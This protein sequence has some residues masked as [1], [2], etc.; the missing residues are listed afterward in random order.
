MPGKSPNENRIKLKLWLKYYTPVTKG[1]NL[2]KSTFRD[3]KTGGLQF[4]GKKIGTYRRIRKLRKS[5]ISPSE[6]MKKHTPDE[7]ELEAQRAA[8][9]DRNIV[10]SITVPLYN[11]RESFL[12]E[13]IDSVRAQTY[14]G[15]ELCL[16]DGSDEKHD[17][18]GRICREYGDSD[19]RIRYRKLEKNLGVSGN[20]NA[21][22]EMATGEF[23][24]FLDHDDVLAPS[25]LFRMAEVLSRQEADVLYTDEATFLSPDIHHLLSIHLKPDFAIDNLRANNY[26]C[27]FTAI[28][29]SLLDRVGLY[30]SEC[31][32]SQDHDMMLRLAAVTDRFVHIPEPLYFWRA[33]LNSTALNIET[34][35]Y[36]AEAG[37][38]AVSDSLRAAGLQASVESSS[39]SPTIYRIRYELTGR[40]KISIIIQ[41]CDRVF[42]LKR[43]LESIES[44]TTYENYE[45]ILI[46]N[47]SKDPGTFDYYEEIKERWSNIR[48]LYYKEKW[49]WSAANN[50]GVRAA[51]GDYY[52]LLNNDTEVITPDW[53]EEMLMY[54]QR[55][56]VGAVGAMLY[57]PNNRIQ[58]AGVILGLNGRAAGHAVRD[59]PRGAYGYAGRLLYAQDM[60]AVTGACAMIDRKVW[61]EVGGADEAYPESLNDI[62]LC[63][64]IRAAGYLIVWT[65]HAELFHYERVSRGEKDTE[66]NMEKE[67]EAQARFRAAWG[68]ELEAGDPYYNPNLSLRNHFQPDDGTSDPISGA[69]RPGKH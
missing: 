33:S 10:F 52:L 31:D 11:T 41:T 6:W 46:E 24:A 26:I 45:I 34:K 8:R 65:P 66:E 29:R 38:R 4:T 9:F 64:R 49:N 53:I 60:T 43:C 37:R 51:S 25:A 27:H 22:L 42:Y 54:A 40:P 23:T 61:D 36:A 12:R 5:R 21:C 47:N 13:M 14:P 18:V 48:I 15:W 1:L 19:G 28:R 67:N 2:V 62:D 20:T 50:F 7:K 39:A 17:Y 56:D 58:H 69:A 55:P 44:K 63:M 68:K 32:G 59:E 57:Y 30:R 35:D 16:A 3:L